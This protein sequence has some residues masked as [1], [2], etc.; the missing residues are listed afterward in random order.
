MIGDYTMSEA[1]MYIG[2]D[3]LP[4]VDG[5]YTVDPADYPYVHAGLGG[6]TTD[7]FTVNGLNGDIYIIGYV[8]LGGQ[9]NN[10]LR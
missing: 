4:V 1:R 2:N 9:E 8:V 7:T 5:N 6:A 3:I 10:F